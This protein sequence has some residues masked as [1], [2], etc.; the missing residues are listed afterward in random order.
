MS[1][2]VTMQIGTKA[3]RMTVDRYYVG[4]SLDRYKV[5]AGEK[6]IELQSNIPE[7]ERTNSKKRISWKITGSNFNI[8]TSDD[9]A[10]AIQRLFREIEEEIL[11]RKRPYSSIK[12]K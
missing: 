10:L 4:E 9:A 2:Q 12:Q 11:P 7:L 6:E 3:F 1:F 5:S 8:G